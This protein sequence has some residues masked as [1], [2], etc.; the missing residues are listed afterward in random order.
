MP[1]QHAIWQVGQ[2]PTPLTTARL[3]NEQ[4]LEDMIVREPAILPS[5]WMLIGQRP[6][7]TTALQ[8]EIYP[9]TRPCT[10]QPPAR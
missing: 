2:Q 8:G 1:I 9:C 6:V 10:H 7:K 5:Q 4:Q 3:A